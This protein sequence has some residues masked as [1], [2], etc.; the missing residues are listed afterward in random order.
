MVFLQA[1]FLFTKRTVLVLDLC[2][3]EGSDTSEISYV[4]AEIMKSEITNFA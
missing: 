1:V 3:T 2:T 4:L